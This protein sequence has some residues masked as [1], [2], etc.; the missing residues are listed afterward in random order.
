MRKNATL[1]SL[2]SR[3]RPTAPKGLRDDIDA[4]FG[5]VDRF[6]EHVATI[7][8]NRNLTSEGR[9]AA[10]RDVLNKGLMDHFRQLQGNVKRARDHVA[11]QRAALMPTGP[12]KTDL[13]REAQRREI[14]ELLGKM[15]MPE[16][17]HMASGSKNPLVVEAILYAPDPAMIGLPANFLADIV[18]NNMEQT[19]GSKL[20]EL[21]ALEE[22]IANADAAIQI[23]G[24]DMRRLSELDDRLF[25]EL[26]APP[27][28]GAQGRVAA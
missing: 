12:D 7:K 20:K 5:I 28:D 26:I 27:K 2:L 19:H 13:F 15:S 25:N 22:D 11:A 1:D 16:R 8:S 6:G 14:R 3:L 9:V 17:M 21:D 10:T 4:A 23:A 24:I 18:R